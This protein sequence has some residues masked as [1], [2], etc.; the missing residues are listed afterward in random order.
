DLE[1]E[2]WFSP[3]DIERE[4]VT[5]MIAFA[6]NYIKIIEPRCEILLKTP[7]DILNQIKEYIEMQL[8]PSYLEE[9]YKRKVISERVYLGIKNS[10]EQAKRESSENP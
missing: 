7:S 5:T 6:E 10:L 9:L 3:F 2:E 1:D 8:V 4:D